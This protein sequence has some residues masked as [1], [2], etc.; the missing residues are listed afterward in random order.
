MKLG[1]FPWLAAP[2]ALL[3][4][5]ALSWQ[6][7][8]GPA[9]PLV[10]P[11]YR[12]EAS[13]GDAR[14]ASTPV[15]LVKSLPR[16]GVGNRLKEAVDSRVDATLE[17]AR[18]AFGYQQLAQL[19]RGVL[20]QGDARVYG[21]GSRFSLLFNG[22][23]CYLQEVV[24]PLTVALGHDGRAGWVLAS[25]GEP[26]GVEIGDVTLPQLVMWMIDG[27]WLSG[28]GPVRVEAA[29]ADRAIIPSHLLLSL[30][31]GGSSA[32]LVLDDHTWLPLTLAW[33]TAHGAE[34]WEFGAWNRELGVALPSVLRRSRGPRRDEFVVLHRVPAPEF[35]DNPYAPERPRLAEVLGRERPPIRPPAPP[36]RSLPGPPGGASRSLG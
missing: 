32:Q 26:T 6:R 21:A 23:G 1:Y 35:P 5:A 28:D 8:A 9:D 33:T 13:P 24:G 22:R 17:R 19:P 27:T 15:P 4:A 20:L 31:R 16:A 29:R 10:D 14:V 11:A 34:T 30:A 3:L 7:L 12:F 36:A 25:A 2:A 18:Q